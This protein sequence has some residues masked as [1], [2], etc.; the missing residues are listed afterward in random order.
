MARAGSKKH[1]ER[2]GPRVTMIAQDEMHWIERH[3]ALV[4]ELWELDRALDVRNVILQ[5]LQ[6]HLTP[7]E[8]T[9]LTATMREGGLSA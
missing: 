1:R 5:R 7:E 2:H 8:K 9:E 6:E 4:S 3:N